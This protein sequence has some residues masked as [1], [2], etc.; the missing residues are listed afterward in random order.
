VADDSSFDQLMIRLRTGDDEAARR[1]FQRYAQRL[2]GLARLHLDA[3]TRRKVDPEDVLQSVFRSF[4][5]Q[6]AD[7][8][9]QLANWNSLW[10]I[11]VVITL[12]KCIRKMKYY[13][14]EIRNV[15]REIHDAP[16]PEDSNPNWDPL[17]SDPTPEQGMILA[18]TV[19]ELMRGLSDRERQMLTL[20]LQGYTPREI[21]AQVGRTERTVHRL[22]AQIRKRLERMRAEYL[23]DN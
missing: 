14:A 3:L 22:L 5:L 16:N 23:A 11:L 1:V 6:H 7:G 19:E 15:R 10:S 18:E 2:I 12:R 17:D 4:F 8:K 13:H 9:L 21:S 20:S